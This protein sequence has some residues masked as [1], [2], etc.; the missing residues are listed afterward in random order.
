MFHGPNNTQYVH[1]SLSKK[2][3]NAVR[4][5]Y[6]AFAMF[7]LGIKQKTGAKFA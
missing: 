2:N 7:E 6:I 4:Y 3:N 5:E 1:H